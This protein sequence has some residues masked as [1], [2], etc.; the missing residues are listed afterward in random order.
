MPQIVQM[1]QN[2]TDIEALKMKDKNQPNTGIAFITNYIRVRKIGA[3]GGTR[4]HTVYD[5]QILSL[6]RATNFATPAYNLDEINYPTSLSPG[7][8]I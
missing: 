8:I 3:D 4:T 6:L 2:G 5:R 1:N 7:H